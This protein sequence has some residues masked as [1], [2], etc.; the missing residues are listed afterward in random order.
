MNK[1]TWC[2]D[3]LGILRELCQPFSFLE[4]ALSLC[5]ATH[6]FI[7]SFIVFFFLLS[8]KFQFSFIL[9]NDEVAVRHQYEE[10]D[11]II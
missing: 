10:I 1:F 11:L 9:L 3:L 4:Y 2:N 6:L 5:R 8:F 7:H